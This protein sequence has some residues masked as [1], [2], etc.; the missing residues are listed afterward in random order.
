[1][2]GRESTL[3]L[4]IPAS[5]ADLVVSEKLVGLRDKYPR[6]KRGLRNRARHR[7][8]AVLLSRFFSTERVT[9]P[10]F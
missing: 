6:D 1:M 9:A 5:L 7:V 2:R 8:L 10:L 3:L 4:W